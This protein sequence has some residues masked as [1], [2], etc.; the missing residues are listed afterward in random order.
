MQ[1]GPDDEIGPDSEVSTFLADVVNAGGLHLACF[2]RHEPMI[3][4]LV[5]SFA[6]SKLSAAVETWPMR[7]ADEF[8]EAEGLPKGAYNLTPL[9]CI[10][11]GDCAR[12]VGA[13]GKYSDHDTLFEQSGDSGDASIIPALTTLLSHPDAARWANVDAI[14]SAPNGSKAVNVSWLSLLGRRDQPKALETCDLLA[15]YSLLNADSLRRKL[16]GASSEAKLRD[17]LERGEIEQLRQWRKEGVAQGLTL[18]DVNWVLLRPETNSLIEGLASSADDGELLREVLSISDKIIGLRFAGGASLLHRAAAANRPRQLGILLAAGADCI[19]ERTSRLDTALHVAAAASADEV[20]DVLLGTVPGRRCLHEKNSDMKLPI[21]LVDKSKKSASANAAKRIRRRLTDAALEAVDPA[22]A[23]AE[24]EAVAAAALAAAAAAA[25][26]EAAAADAK[27]RK[28]SESDQREGSTEGA[29]GGDTVVASSDG[30]SCDAIKSQAEPAVVAPLISQAEALHRKIM[31]E[32]TPSTRRAL[33][34]ELAK[35]RDARQPNELNL[36]QSNVPAVGLERSSPQPAAS[37]P[38]SA[39]IASASSARSSESASTPPNTYVHV[40][41]AAP[42]AKPLAPSATAS[43]T[44]PSGPLDLGG[45][46]AELF[47]KSPWRLLIIRQAARDLSSLEL[48][49]KRS[50]L[51]SLA[52]LAAGIWSGHDVKH[53]AGPSIPSELS[54]YE[55]KF[56]KGARSTQPIFRTSPARATNGS[57]NPTAVCVC[58]AVIWTVGIDFIPLVGLY[59][60]TVR[61]WAVDRSHDDAQRSISRVCAIHKRGLSSVIN[62]KLRSRVQ[63]VRGTSVVLPKSYEVAP[64]GVQSLAHLEEKWGTVAG[65][66]KGLAEAAEGTTKGAAPPCPSIP[67]PSAAPEK[68]GDEQFTVRYPPAVEQEDAY[69][70]VK[71]YTLERSLVFSILAATFTEK[72]EFP[73]LPDESASAL[74]RTGAPASAHA[75]IHPRVCYV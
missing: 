8:L 3:R 37:A 70:L 30:A 55:S 25:E 36:G 11:A 72:L 18:D 17:M 29:P 63:R 22:A 49:D 43:S 10:L 66:A 26:A 24:A 38:S 23:A 58:C 31:N 9:L 35:P 39:P 19:Q 27:S 12:W 64:D 13:E 51:K 42:P 15:R 46:G 41:A 21:D 74:H 54:L 50:A 48:W 7:L 71:F 59:Q 60:Q 47:E 69:N 75:R 62:R 4:F 1:R 68:E 34:V 56:G 57:Y 53:L 16:R 73:F 40:D 32:N 67:S 44:A 61:I 45:D 33:E 65:V 6:P 52:T 5:S 14:A 20:V 28:A 2:L